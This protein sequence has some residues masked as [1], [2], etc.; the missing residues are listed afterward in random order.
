MCLTFCK[1]LCETEGTVSS[2]SRIAQW[3]QHAM[4]KGHTGLQMRYSTSLTWRESS[5]P[6]F[7]RSSLGAQFET[8][9]YGWPCASPFKGSLISNRKGMNSDVIREAD[10]TEPVNSSVV[11]TVKGTGQI[12]FPLPVPW[13]GTDFS[14]FV[15]AEK[16]A[17]NVTHVK[18]DHTGR[19]RSSHLQQQNV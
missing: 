13:N 18:T 12:W 3:P 1:T 4:K 2:F 5:F 19:I 11:V 14:I 6:Y 7:V 16:W 10:R 15:S 8:T 9:E 17:F